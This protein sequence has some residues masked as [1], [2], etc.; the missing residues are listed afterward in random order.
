ML[1]ERILVISSE[2]ELNI[3]N[4]QI[5]ERTEELENDLSYRQLVVYPIIKVK[6]TRECYLCYK[7]SGETEYRLEGNL[8]LGFGG[9]INESDYVEGDLHNTI[10]N[11]LGRELREELGKKFKSRYIKKFSPIRLSTTNVDKAH[12][13]I[14]PVIETEQRHFKGE[15]KDQ[16]LIM[17]IDELKANSDRFENW[18]KYIIEN[19]L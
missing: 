12:I 3:E 18:S 15:K 4:V 16:T 6:M 2:D 7:R 17:N 8:C 1:K 19:Y 13:G 9:H 5:M 11:A 14:V 10:K